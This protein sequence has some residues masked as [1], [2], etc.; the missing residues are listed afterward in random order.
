MQE[1]VKA[2]LAGSLF[3][4]CLTQSAGARPTVHQDLY[5]FQWIGE[6]QLSPRGDQ[7]ALVRTTVDEKK[8]GYETSIWVTSTRHPEEPRKLTP[9]P[10]DRAPRWSPDGRSLAFVS[11]KKGQ[12]VVTSADGSVSHKFSPLPRPVSSPLWSPDGQQL[13]FLCDANAHD[14]TKKKVSDVSIIRQAMYRLNGHGLLDPSRPRQLWIQSV[15]GGNPRQLTRGDY[16]VQE[17]VFVPDGSQLMFVADP[18]AENL[19]GP[20]H[21]E[22]RQVSVESG[23]TQI[24]WDL[25]MVLWGLSLSPDGQQLAFHGEASGPVRS[26]VQPDLFVLDR[27]G[28]HPRNLTANY[29]FDMG[30][31]VLGDQGAP[32]GGGGGGLQWRQGH[33]LDVAARQG[34]AVLVAVDPVNG[35]V[36]ELTHGDQAVQSFACAAEGTVVCKVS[37]PTLLNE[38]FD[39]KGQALT[40][41]NQ[42]LFDKLDL[43]SPEEVVYSSFDGRKIQAWLQKPA[44]FDD[45][46]KYP[47]ILNIH[48]GPHAA[49]GWVFDHEFQ[50]AAGRGYL[51][52]YPN[53]RGSTS[54]GQEFG[55]IIQYHYPGDDYLD[56][57]AGLDTLLKRGYVDEKRLGVT[58]GSG[59]G[60]LTDWT[61]GH[62]HR[63][64]AAVSQRDISDWASW[65]YS[66]DLVLFRPSWFRHP[67]FEDPTEYAQRSP[68]TYVQEITTPIMFVLG[69]EDTRTPPE[70]GGERLFRALK[71]LKRPTVMVRFP[72][73][74]HD[75]SR[76]GEPKH[77]VDRL[78]HILGWF[79]HWLLGVPKPEYGL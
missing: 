75:L 54:Y 5:D 12:L 52:L 51:V 48:G 46:K 31:G 3:L 55:N 78:D 76:S 68:I 65:W 20:R 9:G 53:P 47:L 17:P 16:Q 7:V 57:M 21:T 70:S 15:K 35:E 19:D 50:A 38:I 61:V 67:P 41:L 74:N 77:R 32:S 24:L 13:A 40:H 69:D 2:W 30:S 60:L 72:R 73:E 36:T 23:A 59:G 22:I 58:G 43:S 6:M 29:D 1:R 64:G 62:T 11:G 49:Y 42:Q 44:D 79:D 8:T 37:T 28:Q 26:Y 25:P 14:F 39:L 63:F 4:L 45:H 27:A 33:W 10:K 71:Y 56:L 34:R 66:A 18:L